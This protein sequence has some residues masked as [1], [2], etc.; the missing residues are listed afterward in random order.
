V[1]VAR[2]PYRYVLVFQVRSVLLA[3]LCTTKRDPCILIELFHSWCFVRPDRCFSS[4]VEANPCEDLK[5]TPST[6]QEKCLSSNMELL[7]RTKHSNCISDRNKRL[8]KP[9][10]M[11]GGLSFNVR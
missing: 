5:G 7:S 8:Y 10:K 2:P 4:A 9:H 3:V 1:R 11:D 6:L